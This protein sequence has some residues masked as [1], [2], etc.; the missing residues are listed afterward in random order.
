MKQ[1][2]SCIHRKICIFNHDKS[3]AQICEHYSEERDSFYG[4]Q[5][6]SKRTGLTLTIEDLYKDLTSAQRAIEKS[7]ESAQKIS[8]ILYIADDKI[9]TIKAMKLN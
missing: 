7:S 3:E 6:Y 8:E 2:N 9:F 1:C 5:F 4:I